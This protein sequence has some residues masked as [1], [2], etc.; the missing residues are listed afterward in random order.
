MMIAREMGMSEE[1]FWNSD[2][3][4]FCKCYEKFCERKIDE[5]KALYGR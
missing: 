2:P 5:V 1:E 3:I 4:F